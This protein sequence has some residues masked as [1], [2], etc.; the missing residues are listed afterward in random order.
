MGVIM[1]EQIAAQVRDLEIAVVV[2]AAP[3][4]R[5]DV[6]DGSRQR[7]VTPRRF[8]CVFYRPVQ[9]FLG[10]D[11]FGDQ[12]TCENRYCSERPVHGTGGV[13]ADPADPA[14]PVANAD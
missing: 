8:V 11:V 5:D 2:G 14:I 7:V 10:P 1:L 3:R 6:V 13:A 4:P 12:F 9:Q